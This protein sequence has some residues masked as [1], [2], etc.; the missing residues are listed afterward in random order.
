MREREVVGLMANGQT[1]KEIG[2]TLG[3]SPR[4]VEIHRTNA[5]SKLAARHSSEAVRLWLEAG[6]EAASSG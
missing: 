1:N 2:R 4:T 5:L 6:G 3:I